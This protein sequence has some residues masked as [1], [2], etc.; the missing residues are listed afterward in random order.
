MIPPLIVG[1]ISDLYF[2]VKVENVARQL[3]Y[4]VQWIESADELGPAADPALPN[5]PGEPLQG[6]NG[7]L[8]DQLTAWQPALL[9]FDLGHPAIPWREWIAI[10][11]SSPATRRLP[12]LCF[13]SHVDVAASQAAK[14]AGAEAVVARSRFVTALPE[15]IQQYAR[16]P[17]YPAI[18]AAC[19]EPLSAAARKGLV[20]FNQG[21]YFEAH[22]ELEQ[23]WKEDAGP[24]RDLYRAILQVAVAYLQIQRGNYNGAAKMFLRMRQWFEPLPDTCRGVE[25]AQLCADAAAVRETLLALGPE[26]LKE[27]DRKLLKPVVYREA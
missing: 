11:K 20:Y 7:R 12:I 13:G 14:D 5:R 4:R 6:L 15:L 16:R 1:F 8:L 18:L 17:D 9:I 22:E 3:G 10:L 24:G 27:L 19:Q 21:E 25:V 23:A 2:T 26:R